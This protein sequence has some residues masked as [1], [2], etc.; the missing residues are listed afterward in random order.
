MK[1]SLEERKLVRQALDEC[2]GAATAI[3]QVG[4]LCL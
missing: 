3:E 1:Y 2:T 4:P